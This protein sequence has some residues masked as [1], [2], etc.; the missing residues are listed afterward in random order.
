MGLRPMHL[1]QAKLICLTLPTQNTFL[2]SENSSSLGCPVTL[3]K[4]LGSQ[5]RFQPL[6]TIFSN[7]I[8]LVTAETHFLPLTTKVV[9]GYMG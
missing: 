4:I 6:W 5:E 8:M 7:M 1:K 3:D 9:F 2:N